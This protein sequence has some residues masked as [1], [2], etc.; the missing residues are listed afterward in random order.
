M[1]HNKLLDTIY[2]DEHNY[3]GVEPLYKI[4]K[5]RDKTITKSLVKEY[6]KNQSTHQQTTKDTKKKIYK[7]IYSQSHYS[8]QID[9]TFLPKYK[10]SNDG[11]TVLFTAINVNSRY[12]YVYYSKSKTTKDILNM[13]DKFKNNALEIDT[14]TGDLGSEFINTKCTKWFEDNKIKTFFLN[15]I[16]INSVK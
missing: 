10:K 11:N 9:L 8:F 3:V 12:L 2:Y 7:P 13:L 16:V 6:L 4:V 5:T 15:Q 14:I 1:N